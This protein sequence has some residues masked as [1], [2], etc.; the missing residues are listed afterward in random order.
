MVRRKKPH[1]IPV[2]SFSIEPTVG[3]TTLVQVWEEYPDK[4]AR[5]AHRRAVR[6]QLFDKVMEI[7]DK[8]YLS[9]DSPRVREHWRKI[10][11]GEVPLSAL[12]REIQSVSRQ[13]NIS[14]G[15]TLVHEVARDIQKATKAFDNALREK[16]TKSNL[17]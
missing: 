11:Y 5:G 3:V 7:V 10:I 8:H 12:V 13:K 6:H 14:A 2:D 1:A 17:P 16:N 15:R 4:G 9:S